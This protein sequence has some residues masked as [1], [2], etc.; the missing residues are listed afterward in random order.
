M[1]GKGNEENRNVINEENLNVIHEEN[2]IKKGKGF[3]P[4]K[5]DR[6][7]YVLLSYYS[8]AIAERE[9]KIQEQEKVY[10]ENAEAI[11]KYNTKI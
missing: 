10:N 6:L 9:K 4:E 1:S 11:K 3:T 5:V 8:L 2:E 7:K